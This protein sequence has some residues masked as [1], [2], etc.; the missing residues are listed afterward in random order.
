MMPHYPANHD[1][2]GCR[3]SKAANEILC[4]QILGSVIPILL[5]CC[6]TAADEPCRIG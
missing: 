3:M 6:V 4:N 1:W 2:E 5:E